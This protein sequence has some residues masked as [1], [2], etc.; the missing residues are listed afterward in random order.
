MAKVRFLAKLACAVSKT[1]ATALSTAPIFMMASP[2]IAIPSA[3]G[4]RMA[5][6]LERITSPI[7]SICPPN[8]PNWDPCNAS[9][10]S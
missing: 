4:L 7:T 6:T 3:H 9:L 5:L 2:V 10:A 8:I 1:P